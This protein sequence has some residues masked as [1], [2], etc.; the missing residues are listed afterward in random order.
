MESNE[1]EVLISELARKMT[2]DTQL[3]SAGKIKIGKKNNWL[4]SSSFAHQIDV[5]LENDHDVLLIECK[6]W[7]T[8]NIPPEAF[9]TMWARVI[10]ISKSKIAAG[11]NVRGALVT[12]RSFNRGVGTLA[13]YYKEQMSLFIVRSVDDFIVKAHTH[14]IRVPSIPSG[15]NFGIPTIV[16]QNITTNEIHSEQANQPDT[17]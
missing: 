3:I 5:S 17:D 12:S 16:Q 2:C 4:G 11:R 13:E 9:L 10:D 1:Y 6:C 8:K 15:E 7:N 14:F